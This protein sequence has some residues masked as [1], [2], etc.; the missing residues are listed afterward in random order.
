MW[1]WQKVL[2]FLTSNI[3]S[4]T[5]CNSIKTCVSNNSFIFRRILI[6]NSLFA[7]SSCM[8]STSK[9]FLIWNVSFFV[10]MAARVLVV[11]WIIGI[12]HSST[13]FKK[14]EFSECEWSYLYWCLIIL[15]HWKWLHWNWIIPPLIPKT[16]LMF[17]CSSMRTLKII[18][19][20]SI[21]QGIEIH[22]KLRGHQFI[23]FSLRWII[24]S[25]ESTSE[26]SANTG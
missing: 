18:K 22:L 2:K 15:W 13:H 21:K 25:D 11:S 3:S 26:N 6:F 19:K 9:S 5:V 12:F 7:V 17:K 24:H 10:S 8:A 23:F 1:I 16:I 14:V 20:T 4:S